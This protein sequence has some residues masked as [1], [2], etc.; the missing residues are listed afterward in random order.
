VSKKQTKVLSFISGLLFFSVVTLVLIRNDR[1]I[2]DELESQAKDLLKVSKTALGQA[3]TLVSRVSVLMG[4][5]EIDKE[6][7]NLR[8]TPTQSQPNDYDSL[9]EQAES[10]NAARRDR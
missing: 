9:W 5:P 3:Q 8:R 2:R 7:S 4:K 1:E 10:Q 6:S